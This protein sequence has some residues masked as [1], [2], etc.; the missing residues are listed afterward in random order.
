MVD[1]IKVIHR[2]IPNENWIFKFYILAYIYGIFGGMGITCGAHRL[3]SHRSYK[4][5]YKMRIVLAIANLIAFQNSI[6]DWVNYC[7]LRET[8]QFLQ[9]PS[10]S[11]FD[12]RFKTTECTISLP[13]LMPI[14]ITRNV[15]CSFRIWDGC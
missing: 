6:F 3:W 15:D 5:N 4:A 8:E 7:Y 12:C 9:S 14:H 10:D 2:L 13:T 1:D 11:A